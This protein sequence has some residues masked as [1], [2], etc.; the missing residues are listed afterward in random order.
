MLLPPTLYVI[1]QLFSL[2]II[3]RR[4]YR[5]LEAALR[6]RNRIAHGFRSFEP[7]GSVVTTLVDKIEELLGSKAA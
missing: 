5:F 1:K 3:S 4:D 7:E 2:G 6:R